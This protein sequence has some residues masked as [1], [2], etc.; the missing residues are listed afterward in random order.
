MGEESVDLMTEGVRSLAL[1]DADEQQVVT[2]RDNCDAT[3]SRLI[4]PAVPATWS[5][6]FHKEEPFQKYLSEKHWCP[7]SPQANGWLLL[8]GEYGLR[9]LPKGCKWNEEEQEYCF[10]RVFLGDQ[11]NEG[12]PDLVFVKLASSHDGFAKLLQTQ[13]TCKMLIEQVQELQRKCDLT[14]QVEP[15]LKS[16]RAKLKKAERDLHRLEEKCKL[17]PRDVECF[18]IVELKVC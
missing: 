8:Q 12:R 6:T 7:T 16:T 13:L 10:P 9:L 15:R 5:H 18:L 11:F 4:M 14:A 1:D 3:R 2:T 17:S